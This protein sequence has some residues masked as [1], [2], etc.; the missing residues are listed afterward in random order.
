MSATLMQV[1]LLQMQ[2]AESIIEDVVCIYA[3]ELVLNSAGLDIVL[4]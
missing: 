4:A 3:Q 2:K 1:V